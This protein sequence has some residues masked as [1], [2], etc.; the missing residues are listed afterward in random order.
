MQIMGGSKET[1]K[2]LLTDQHIMAH[3]SVLDEMQR[4]MTAKSAHIFI[5]HLRSQKRAAIFHGLLLV[6]QT[7]RS[8][9][10]YHAR[11]EE[12]MQRTDKEVSDIEIIDTYME[13][14]DLVEST[15]EDP[16]RE[17]FK[18]KSRC[19]QLGYDLLYLLINKGVIAP[20]KKDPQ[21][22]L[23]TDPKKVTEAADDPLYESD[24]GQ[25]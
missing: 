23:D 8:L 19:E 10:F 9:S 25:I 15:Y 17:D 14:L 1:I 16:I 13:I 24:K 18:K 7:W 21:Q 12:K 6:S 4:N 22:R 11:N 3:P 20:G 2:Q 5:N